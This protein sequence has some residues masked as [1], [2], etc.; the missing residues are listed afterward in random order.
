MRRDVLGLILRGLFVPT[1]AD[2]SYAGAL[3]NTDVVRYCSDCGET[4]PLTIE[5]W[6][7]TK[8]MKVSRSGFMYICR[9]CRATRH[10]RWYNNLRD[11]A[12][13]HYGGENGIRCACCGEDKRPFLSLD[14]IDND[15]AAH[16][17]SI[18]SATGNSK[19]TVGP[20]SFLESLRKNGWNANLQVMCHNC[21]M[22]RYLNG[23]TC[24][25][26]DS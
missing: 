11:E 6:F 7:T 19:G 2:G 16:R 15:G 25:H 9:P 8:N 22:G 17:A 1:L 3:I 5:H 4:K 21:N 26:I 10:K 12:L 14:H 23:G 24:P 20:G 18:G 13:R